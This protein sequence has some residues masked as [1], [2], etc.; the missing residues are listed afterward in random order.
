MMYHQQNVSDVFDPPQSLQFSICSKDKK[1]INGWLY[2]PQ[3]QYLDQMNSL[4]SPSP[5][6]LQLGTTH[7]IMSVSNMIQLNPCLEVDGFHNVEKILIDLCLCIQRNFMIVW[8][9]LNGNIWI[10]STSSLI[11]YHQNRIP[12]KK[13]RDFIMNC[14]L[15]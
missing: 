10:L 14:Q 5:P 12:I 8:T 4:S 15:W 1:S 9:T 2:S 13:K 6:T 3:P 7:I 11:Q